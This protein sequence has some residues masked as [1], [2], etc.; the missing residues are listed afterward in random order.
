MIKYCNT[1]ILPNTRPNIQFDAEGRCNG[2]TLDNKRNI[3]WVK[4]EGDFQKLVLETKSKN[5]IY[6]CVIPVS[7]GK[8][9]TWQVIKALEY[10]LRPLCVT[11]KT[12]VRTKL[13]EANLNN[14]VSLGVNHI[15][16]TINPNVEKTFTYNDPETI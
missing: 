3:N 6:D 5:R 12:P 13:G 15:D 9:S 11:W 16:F 7:G 4:R 1:C 2:A 10:G 8:D 14:L